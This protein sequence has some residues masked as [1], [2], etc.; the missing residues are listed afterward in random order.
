MATMSAV[1]AVAA[2]DRHLADVELAHGA[3]LGNGDD[4]RDLIWHD[5][6]RKRVCDKRKAARLHQRNPAQPS[7]IGTGESTDRLVLARRAERHEIVVGG[8]GV[9]ERSKH[10]VR[11]VGDESHVVLFE[12]LQKPVRPAHGRAPAVR[13]RGLAHPGVPCK[14]AATCKDARMRWKAPMLPGLLLLLVAP[15]SFARQAAP[16]QDYPTQPITL[17]IPFAAG[18]S[19]SIVARTVADKMSDALG[20]QI[21]I[22]NRPGAGGTLATRAVARNAPDGYTLVLTTNATLATAPSLFRNLG[23]DPRRDF[24]PIGLIAATANVVAV[25]PRFPGRSLRELVDIGRAAASPIPY[26]SPGVG[27][28]NH[29]TIELLAHRTGMK[30]SHVPYKG[31]GPALNDLI[32]GHIELLISAIPN[33]HAHIAAG[34]MRALAITGANRSPLVPGVPTMAEAGFPGYDVPLRFGL[35]APAGTPPAIIEALNRALNAALASEDVRQRLA[36]E[37]AE[38]AP[39]TPAQYAAMI[40]D[41]LAMWS[42]LANTIDLKPD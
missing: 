15:S 20:R 23:Y 41:E 13:A 17:V 18:G 29:L 42:D 32:G 1:P 36:L 35:A 16:A 21:I 40:D 5:Q 30:V 24:A 25:N 10:I 28:L 39:T 6:R 11:D 38:P 3:A 22:E 33:A 26:G 34:T 19:S 31:A 8:G 9:D 7:H 2:G 14:A 4:R 37:G 27:T 12:H